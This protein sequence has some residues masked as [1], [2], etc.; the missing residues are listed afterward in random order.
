MKFKK[1][2]LLSC[3]VVLAVLLIVLP[4]VAFGAPGPVTPVDPIDVLEYPVLPTSG[5]TYYLSTFPKG[6]RYSEGWYGTFTEA[7]EATVV[8]YDDDLGQ[9]LFYLENGKSLGS[10]QGGTSVSWVSRSYAQSLLRSYTLQE[11]VEPYDSE[12]TDVMESD[13]YFVGA[14]AGDKLEQKFNPPLNKE[15]KLRAFEEAHPEPVIDGVY[16]PQEENWWLTEEQKEYKEGLLT[17]KSSFQLEAIDA[18]EEALKYQGKVDLEKFDPDRFWVG[19]GGNWSDTAHWSTSTGGAGGASVPTSADNVYFD[20]NSFSS[21]S[22]TVTVNENSYF[23]DMDWTGVTD[24]PVFYGVGYSM[25]AYGSITLNSGLSCSNYINLVLYSS[26]SEIFTSGGVTGDYTINMSGSGTYTIQDSVVTSRSVGSRYGT[27]DTNDQAITCDTFYSDL[28]SPR[29]I[30]LGSSVVSC[31]NINITTSSLTLYAETSTIIVSGTG[32]FSSYGY[33][34]YEVQLNGTSHTV[35]GSNTFT[36]LTR[37]GTATKTDSVTFEADSTQTVT[38]TLNLSGNSSTNRLLVQ[39]DTIGTVATLD[40]DGAIV[41][42]NNAD[43]MDITGS[44][45]P[46]GTGVNDGTDWDISACDGLSGDCQG[47]TGITFT[48]PAEQTWA[49]AD[50]GSWS[51]VGNWSGRVPLPQ[52]DVVWI[53]MNPSKTITLDMPRAGKSIDFSSAT[54]SPTLSV[55]DHYSIYGSLDLTGIGTYTINS[56]SIYWMGRDSYM[57]NTNNKQQARL[58]IIAYGGTLTL[59][60]NFS[61]GFGIIVYVGELDLNGYDYDGL[62]FYSFDAYGVGNR[63]LYFGSGNITLIYTGNILRITSSTLYSED[64]TVVYSNDLYTSIAT[65]NSDGNIFNDLVVEGNKNFTLEITGSN[66]FNTITVD[67]SEA[68][69]TITTTAGTTQTMANFVCAQ[70]GTTVV[71][72]NSSS[73]GSYYTWTK[74]GGGTASAPY[75]VVQDNHGTPDKTWYSEDGTNVSGNDQW[76]F[77]VP[78]SP[79]SVTA[80]DGDHTDK[81]TVGWTGSAGATGYTVYRDATDLVAG[82]VSTY[83][84]TG[85][86]APTITGGSA[87][88]SDGEYYDYVLL[89]VTGE[90]VND[91]TVHT[92]KVVATNPIGSSADSNTDSGYRGAD[93]LNYQWYRSSADSD[94][95]YSSLAGAATEDYQDETAPVAGGGRYYKCY[96]TSTDATPVYSGT[97]RGYRNFDLF[98]PAG[99]TA[100]IDGNN[101]VLTWT[102]GTGADKT[103]IVRGTSR[104]PDSLTDGEEIYFDTDVTYTDEGVVDETSSYYYS[105]WGYSTEAGLYSDDYSTA[106]GGGSRMILIGLVALGMGLTFFASW[107]VYI[108]TSLAAAVCWLALGILWI[109]SPASIGVTSSEDWTNYLGYVFLLMAIVPVMLFLRSHLGTRVRPPTSRQRR[110]AYA[111]RLRKVTRK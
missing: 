33:T 73:P 58:Y 57:L 80:T 97:D 51:D 5:V 89:G 70:S 17:D 106:V 52:D 32:N 50:G 9:C 76:Y 11:L 7:P 12:V 96:L 4:I 10:S 95:D 72:L 45:T 44:G 103:A 1:I 21:G 78:S 42:V 111:E 83:D 108:L 2:F 20:A 16:I 61:T 46:A 13:Y 79:T 6:L 55:S 82:D 99:F 59:N 27:L 40:C 98:A 29:T 39:S 107:R 56:K 75:L 67:R 8:M 64:S 104:F 49:D 19:D 81:V 15:E 22:Q 91:G 65:I 68:A 25:Y 85:A 43:F 94:A 28:A 84:D 74:T 36:N 47:N 88:A 3:V 110:E 63:T 30:Y 48:T 87:T 53:A 41:E 60:S 71:T 92:Y 38:G 31:S 34:F 26:G 86:D 66:T 24:N 102:L 35:T 14:Q 90:S 109:G 69:K 77:D 105:A 54:N 93:I 62:Y 101:I 37:T 18:F 23:L 100:T